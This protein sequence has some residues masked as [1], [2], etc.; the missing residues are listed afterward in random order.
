MIK[1]ILEN[2]PNTRQHR[3]HL[4][5][6][7]KNCKSTIRIS[8]PYITERQIITTVS[9]LEVRLL[10]SLREI[11]IIFG[12]TS[13]ESL[14]ALLTYGVECR[15]LPPHPKLHA[16]VYI[17]GTSS[18]IITS[19][20]F[21]YNALESNIEAGV[22]IFGSEVQPIISWFDSLWDIATPVTTKHLSDLQILTSSIRCDFVK[23][24]NRAK[25]LIPFRPY[26]ETT[27]TNPLQELLTSSSRFFIC[28]S[29]RRDGKRTQ[30]G[31][32]SLEEE[33]H[34]RGFV[35]AWEDFKYPSHMKLVEPGDTIF[36]FAKGVGIIGIGVATDCYKKLPP[37][38]PDR[39]SSIYEDIEWRIPVRWL[40]WT[41]PIG[42][43]HWK[44]PNT[45]FLDIS[46]LKYIDFRINVIT[47]FL[48]DF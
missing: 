44:S 40:A 34:N 30:T 43:Y 46:D 10:T 48:G 21:T 42:A 26:S 24:K 1:F 39:I 2:G 38:H 6:L 22:E 15:S 17:F 9:N 32:F 11:D 16:K 37:H 45:T 4:Y 47:H 20:N 29:N 3:D 41:D 18:A 23:I 33:M 28:N 14:N 7:F 36:M 19:A 5:N 35:A 31:G 25:S 12:S 27:L 13:I 8:S